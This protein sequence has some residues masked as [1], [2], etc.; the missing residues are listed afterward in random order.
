MFI[1]IKL[2]L[3]NNEKRISSIPFLNQSLILCHKSFC[4]R[5]HN[6]GHFGR[7]EVGE[8]NGWTKK[9][10]NQYFSI[11]SFLNFS[12]LNF[13][14]S[15]E[16]P[17]DFFRNSK[18]TP[19]SSL[20]FILHKCLNIKRHLIILITKI[21]I[22]VFMGFFLWLII[23]KPLDRILN[24]ISRSFLDNFKHHRLNKWI[25]I[26]SNVWLYFFFLWL[27]FHI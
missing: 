4:H 22:W 23:L 2:S 20:G 15:I 9:S 25:D 14:F 27:H 18:S 17:K 7:I 16:I 3:S 12:I 26:G 13:F 10:H 11:F 8:K 5:I 1:A 24:W 6:C 21:R 19:L